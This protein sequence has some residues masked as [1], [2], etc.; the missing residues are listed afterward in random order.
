MDTEVVWILSFEFKLL[1][2]F[3][4]WELNNISIKFESI[5]QAYFLHE[6]INCK[7]KKQKRGYFCYDF[8]HFLTKKTIKVKSTIGT[9]IL[10]SINNMYSTLVFWSIIKL[11]LNVSFSK[12]LMKFDKYAIQNCCIS[13]L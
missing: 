2:M 13:Y 3:I 9:E 10:F 7:K 8:V 12:R 1:Y 5:N 6:I 11:K 4:F